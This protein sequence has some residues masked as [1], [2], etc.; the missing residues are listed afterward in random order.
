MSEKEL[1]K[2]QKY[3]LD[4]IPVYEMMVQKAT[5]PRVRKS[6]EKIIEE[7]KADVQILESHT[8]KKTEPSQSDRRFFSAARTVLG[9]KR[10]M[11]MMAGSEHD[12]AKEHEKLTGEYPWLKRIAADEKRHGDTLIRLK[13]LG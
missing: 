3:V 5:D 9:M 1:L 13:R 10:T 8:G 11:N 4:S 6:L 12:A 2:I 7:K